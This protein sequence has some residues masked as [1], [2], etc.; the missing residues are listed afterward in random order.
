MNMSTLASTTCEA[1]TRLRG[2]GCRERKS[3][4]LFTTVQHYRERRGQ[5]IWASVR[6]PYTAAAHW[7]AARP[8]I[9][10]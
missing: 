5:S 3:T 8:H 4:D 7:H 10:A 1:A 9:A 2:G 6:M